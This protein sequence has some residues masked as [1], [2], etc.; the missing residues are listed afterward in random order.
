MMHLAIVGDSHAAKTFNEAAIRKGFTMSSVELADL[1]LVAQDT[2]TYDTGQRNLGPIKAIIAR[3]RL[4]SKPDA[5]I[6]H[7]CQVPPGF[8]RSLGLNLYHM[9]ETLRIKDALARAVKPEQIVI[10]CEHPER[11][12]PQALLEYVIPFNCPVWPVTFEEAEF[13][14]IAINMTLA[15]Q[16]DHTNRLKAVCDKLGLR[17]DAIAPILKHDGRI[18]H[19]SYLQPGRWQ[20]SKHL[21]RDYYTLKEIENG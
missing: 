21:L 4:Q 8:T 3:A 14:K 6:L 7:S 2:P 13:S 19:K 5:V 16:V 15:A 18:G 20:D 9:A 10:G 1:V 12:L 11:A 17:W